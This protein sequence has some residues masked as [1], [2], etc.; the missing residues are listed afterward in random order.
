[1]ILCHR[2]G[3]GAWDARNQR[4]VLFEL[5]LEGLSQITRW[6]PLRL[7]PRRRRRGHRATG[8]P[9][10]WTQLRRAPARSLRRSS[11]S[12]RARWLIQRTIATV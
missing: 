11:L 4:L 1:M 3:P 5:A 8:T 9:L 2:S 6:P 12:V 10:C 7:R